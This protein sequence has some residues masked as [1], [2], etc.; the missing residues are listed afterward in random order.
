[1]KAFSYLYLLIAAILFIVA[2]PILL[3]A[4]LKQKYRVS[5]PKRFFLYKNPPFKK[6]G[7]WF[8]VCSYGEVVSLKPIL[9]D[10][11]GDINISVT[12]NTGYEMAK[13]YKAD[14]RF[15]PYELWLPFWVNRQKILVVSEAELWY[16]LFF[17]AKLKGAKVILIN[18]RISDNSYKSYQRFSFFYKKIFE[19]IDEVFA[20]SQ[21]DM[22]RLKLL[23]AK[24]IKVCGNIKA[25]G[26]IKTTKEYKKP[27]KSVITLASTHD[28]E[29][30]LL[31]EN[32]RL[33]DD[34]KL[35]VVPRHP[36]RFDEVAKFLKDYANKNRLSFSRFSQSENF[37]SDVVLV[38][39]MGELV[40]I[41]AISDVVLLGGS[42]VKGVGGHNPLEPASFGCK[43]ISGKDYFNQ[44]SLYEL[45]EN[46]SIIDADELPHALVVAKESKVNLFVDIKPIKEAI[47]SVV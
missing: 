33:R 44:K 6:E 15:L 30:K 12:T 35:I 23:G 43:I 26:E 21:K 28:K 27:D 34:M 18:A 37:D 2:F 42:F 29:E 47:N 1:L 8:H 25:Y 46:I 3:L 9:S 7:I 39:C 38:D 11:V 13:K 41:Y 17:M 31:L 5:I 32:M 22:D 36:E 19:N 14:V 20:Q 10:L 45:V 40:N 4:T 24:N 16:M